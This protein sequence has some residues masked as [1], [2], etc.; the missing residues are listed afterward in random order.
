MKFK[1][2]MAVLFV[3]SLFVGICVMPNS[4]A[5]A[6]SGGIIKGRVTGVDGSTYMSQGYVLTLEPTG[7]A[8]Q[9]LSKFYSTTNGMIVLMSYQG[10]TV[11]TPT[12]GTNMVAELATNQVIV[13]GAPSQAISL[14]TYGKK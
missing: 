1:T 14:Y 11:L 4:E 13:H 10:S 3:M 8:T 5:V 7:I 6:D 9:T 12:V 2:T